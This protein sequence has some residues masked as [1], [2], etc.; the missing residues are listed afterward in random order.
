[1]IRA[2]VIVALLALVANAQDTNLNYPRYIAN[3]Q[4]GDVE[5]ELRMRFALVG[6]PTNTDSARVETFLPLSTSGDVPA[7]ERVIEAPLEAAGNWL[8]KA[9][10]PERWHG[11]KWY[12]PT[13]EGWLLPVDKLTGVAPGMAL[14]LTGLLPKDYPPSLIPSFPEPMP[15]YA[16]YDIKPVI[17]MAVHG[18][19]SEDAKRNPVTREAWRIY[20]SP[21]TA[22]VPCLGR[23][24]H[25]DPVVPPSAELS[26]LG[27]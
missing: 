2:A 9:Y 10:A 19:F 14:N 11:V 13:P 23:W 12:L 3:V 8:R 27:M 1:M 18:W 5:R 4:P 6:W 16:P 21:Q 22:I 24:I 26:K 15:E 7:S 20:S 17:T 25:A